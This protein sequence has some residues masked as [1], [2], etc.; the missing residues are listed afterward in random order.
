MISQPT[1]EH[2]GFY[3]EN[4]F[5]AVP[6]FLDATELRTWSRVS[7]E[8][9]HERITKFKPT[10]AAFENTNVQADDYYARVFVQCLRL[11]D[12]WPAMRELIYD[13]RIARWAGLLSGVD[14]IRVWHDQALFKPPFGNPTSYHLDNPYWSFSSRDS[15]SIWIALDDA[16]LENGCMWYL[17][18]T[19]KTARYENAGIGNQ[20]DGLFKVYPEWRKIDP[21]P[22]EVKAGTAVFH[23]GLTAH[24]AGANMS[25]RPR[26]AMTCGFMPEGSTFNGTRN[27]L[28][29]ALFKSLKV[30]DL[31]NDE[32][33]TPLLWTKNRE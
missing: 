7:D 27:I 16:T 18:G 5:L 8:A 13:R 30:G 19:H 23:N 22:V 10:G 6:D 25:N 21:V 9:V 3:Q 17:P 31:L 28:P 26:R 20:I 4:G 2:I 15:I 12:S 32:K 33:Q 14:G 1:Q 11:A 24:G 29:E